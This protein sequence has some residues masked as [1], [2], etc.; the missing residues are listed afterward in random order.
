[1]EIVDSFKNSS[2]ALELSGIFFFLNIF[3]LQLVES[4][5][6]ETKECIQV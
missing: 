6:A 5:D 1:M 4:A 3:H 2:F